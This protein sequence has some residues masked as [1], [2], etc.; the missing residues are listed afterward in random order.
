MDTLEVMQ[1]TGLNK[2]LRDLQI[3]ARAR[4][5]EP[6]ARIAADYGISG[7]AVRRLLL[8]R[9]EGS[10]RTI[11]Q[12]NQVRSLVERERMSAQIEAWVK[13]HPGCTYEEVQDNF[14]LAP[15]MA[16]DLS[17][18]VQYLVL[19]GGRRH[20]RIAGVAPVQW[21]S[22]DACAALATAAEFSSPITREKYD[23]L[24]LL[25]LFQGPSGAW[26]TTRFPSWRA[27]CTEA[28]VEC[29]EPRRAEYSKKWTRQ[30]MV[31]WV[32]RFIME[33]LNGTAEGYQTWARATE[34]APSEPTVR[35]EF[36]SWLAVRTAALEHLRSTWAD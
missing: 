11:R 28:G 30:D 7:E 9:G 17:R 3:I 19:E 27:A 10:I 36:K 1:K 18:A 26:I 24:R 4:T 6:L 5:G 25:G 16:K 8:R 32:A 35:N 2:A 34:G 15:E 22:A 31:E 13:D 29:G 14:A 21:H 20:R 33:T 12:E 23:E